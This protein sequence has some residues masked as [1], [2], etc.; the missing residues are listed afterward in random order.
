MKV[1]GAMFYGTENDIFEL[2]I[3][4]HLRDGSK[5]HLGYQH[6]CRLVNDFVHEGPNGKHVCMVFELVGDSLLS[7][8]AGFKDSMIPY[9]VMKRFAIQLI[10]AVEFVHYYDVIHTDIQQSNIFVKFRDRSLIESGYLKKAP[11]PQQDKSEKEYTPIPSAPLD[12]RRQ[13]CRV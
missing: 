6:V 3:L 1:L 13:P 4:K 8:G 7:F 11:I 2:E 10:G 12:S 5:E 9:P